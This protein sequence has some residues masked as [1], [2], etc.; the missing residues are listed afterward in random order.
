MK[1]TQFA[2]GMNVLA[3]FLRLTFSFSLVWA[4][5]HML[6]ILVLLYILKVQKDW[7]KLK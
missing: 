5:V 4:I 1:F 3:L 6:F 2:I 7:S